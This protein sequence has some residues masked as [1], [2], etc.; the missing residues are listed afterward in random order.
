MPTNEAIPFFEEGRRVTCHAT[1]AVVG[2]RFVTVS[3]DAVGG[4]YAVAQSGAGA[5]VLGVAAYDAAAG[6]PVPVDVGQDMI[7][8][9]SAGAALAAGQSVRSD[10]DGRA[11]PATGPNGTVVHAVGVAMT[12]A[13]LGD[14]AEI[15]LVRHNV[16]GTEVA[17]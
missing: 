4:N 17:A 3:G 7:V 15:R 8:P 2:R 13:A 5:D 9:V 12:A 6:R 1:G 10:V 14:D 16:T 11:V